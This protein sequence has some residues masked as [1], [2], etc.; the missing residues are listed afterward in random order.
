M[1]LDLRR[2]RVWHCAALACGLLLPLLVYATGVLVFGGYAPG[3]PAA[4]YGD[5]LRGLASLR[6]YSWAILLGPLA[7]VLAWRGLWG[8]GRP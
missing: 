4:F 8:L 1:A 7:V 6:W 5:F 3:G 2:G